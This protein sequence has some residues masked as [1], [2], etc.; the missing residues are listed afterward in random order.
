MRSSIWLQNRPDWLPTATGVVIF[1]VVVG[2]LLY[3]H[4]SRRER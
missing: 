2:Y 3:L 4:F 1:V